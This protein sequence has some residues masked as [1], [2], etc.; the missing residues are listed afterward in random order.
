MDVIESEKIDLYHNFE[1]LI[2][3][4]CQ[5]LTALI[6]C[7]SKINKFFKRSVKIKRRIKL[8]SNLLMNVP[9]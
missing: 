3:S 5:N 2:V 4:S 9:I 6:E 7:H 1:I 8:E